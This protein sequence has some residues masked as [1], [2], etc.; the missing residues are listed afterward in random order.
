[1]EWGVIVYGRFSSDTGT[2]TP[3]PSHGPGRDKFVLGI[4]EVFDAARHARPFAQVT[5]L[6]S[7]QTPASDMCSGSIRPPEGMWSSFMLP[8]RLGIRVVSPDIVPKN[9]FGYALGVGVVPEGV[10]L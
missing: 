9:P 3:T 2:Q 5:Y 1:M 6:F 8:G 7:D 4:L 10:R